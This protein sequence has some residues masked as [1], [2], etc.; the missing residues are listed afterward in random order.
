MYTNWRSRCEAGARAFN[1]LLEDLPEVSEIMKVRSIHESNFDADRTSRMRVG[2]SRDQWEG[3]GLQHTNKKSGSQ[4]NR[5]AL[6]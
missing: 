5:F 3:H 4:Y 6:M 1:E 2:A